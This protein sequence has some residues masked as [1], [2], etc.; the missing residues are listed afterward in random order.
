MIL[1]TKSAKVSIEL[2][3]GASEGHIMVISLS[4]ALRTQ[5]EPHNP[6]VGCNCTP[7]PTHK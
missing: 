1:Q 6:K 7:N 4:T 3:P 5:M 2:E